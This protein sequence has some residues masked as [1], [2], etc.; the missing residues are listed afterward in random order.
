MIG[1]LHNKEMMVWCLRESLLV[2]H[3]SMPR[4]RL[5]GGE[6]VVVGAKVG[7]HALQVCLAGLSFPPNLSVNSF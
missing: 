3:Y 4:G 5:G 7:R 6:G 2:P 1:K